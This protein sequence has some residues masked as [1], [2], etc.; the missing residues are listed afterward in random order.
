MELAAGAGLNEAAVSGEGRER[1]L[2]ICPRLPPGLGFVSAA[3]G[4]GS[5]AEARPSCDANEREYDARQV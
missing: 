4:R 5:R 2:H 3:E 1:A